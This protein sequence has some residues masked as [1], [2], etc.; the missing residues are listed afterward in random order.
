MNNNNNTRR[1]LENVCF[2][3]DV[4][5]V[6]TQRHFNVET[7]SSQRY[8]RC[9]DVETTLC[10]YWVL[11]YASYCLACLT[12]ILQPQKYIK[13]NQC[14]LKQINSDSDKLTVVCVISEGH[15]HD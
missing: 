3:S 11:S 1:L 14:Q 2:L 7:T 8:G 12:R 9:I 10:A 4:F 6:G 15:G 13:L 5:S